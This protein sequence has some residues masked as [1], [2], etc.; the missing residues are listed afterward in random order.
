LDETLEVYTT[1]PPSPQ[2]QADLF[3]GQWTSA[4]PLPDGT[5]VG[6]DRADLFADERITWMLDELGPIT[7]MRVLE[8]GPLEGGHTAMLERAGA[9]SVVAVE[10]HQHAFLRC[11][12]VKNLLDL[13]ARFELGDFVG[14]LREHDEP[15]DLCVASGVLY[16]MADPL[17]LLELLGSRAQRVFLWTH[18]YDEAVL[19]ERPDVAARFVPDGATTSTRGGYTAT[20]H[21]YDYGEG[22]HAA[23]FCGGSRPHTSWMSRQD[24]LGALEHYGFS[25]F[26]FAFD[27]P[28]WPH[29]PAFALVAER[30]SGRRRLRWR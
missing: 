2:T 16:H 18:H 28:W 4:V 3:P 19:A 17:E 29:G 13:R 30:P 20:L 6:G 23:S 5:S 14:Y 12:V 11:L 1:A 9:G 7:G 10:A 27:D 24:I 15:F 21:R 26:R 22:A 8:L 25:G